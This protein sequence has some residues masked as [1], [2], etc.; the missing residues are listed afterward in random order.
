MSFCIFR[1]SVWVISLGSLFATTAAFATPP[2]NGMTVSPKL[3]HI[4]L[5]FTVFSGRSGHLMYG[6]LGISWRVSGS[7]IK[8]VHHLELVR[9]GHTSG[10]KRQ[11][12]AKYRYFLDLRRIHSVK[13]KSHEKTE[14]TKSTVLRS[15]VR[16][17][18]L[19][20]PGLQI[21]IIKDPQYFELLNL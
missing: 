4:R 14:E 6:S 3:F 10:G 5:A 15:T 18:L 9:D 8:L 12:A 13:R 17:P 11:K 1:L 19:F 2:N 16:N 7:L 21:R 20:K